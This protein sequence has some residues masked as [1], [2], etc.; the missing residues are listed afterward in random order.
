MKIFC[1]IKSIGYRV[2]SGPWPFYR[3]AILSIYLGSLTQLIYGAPPSLQDVLPSWYQF[4]YMLLT[5]ISAFMILVAVQFMRLSRKALYIER[6]GLTVLAGMQTIYIVNYMMILGI[7][8]APQTWMTFA[9][10]IYGILRIKQLNSEI[11][12][13]NAII[14]QMDTDQNSY[15][16]SDE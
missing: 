15:V 7:P 3:L 9:I 2:Q 4:V 5:N 6:A 14:L 8:K 13:A 16:V 11:K 10:I 1:R 12:K